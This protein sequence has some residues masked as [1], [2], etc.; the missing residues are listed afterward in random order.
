MAESPIQES[1]DRLTKAMLAGSG[2]A[3]DELY[4]FVRGMIQPSDNSWPVHLAKCTEG[5]VESHP[6]CFT[7][8]HD[9]VRLTRR[10]RWETFRAMHGPMTSTPLRELLCG[11]MDRFGRPYIAVLAKQIADTMALI[12]ERATTERPPGEPVHSMDDS[13]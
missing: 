13:V 9:L 2:R 6:E 3:Y 10:L 5:F 7:T 8:P 11:F 1:V 4:E 12:E